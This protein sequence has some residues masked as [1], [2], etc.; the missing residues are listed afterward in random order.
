M[1]KQLEPHPDGFC[2]C[3]GARDEHIGDK[4]CIQSK[5]STAR[6]IFDLP[7]AKWAWQGDAKVVERH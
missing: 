4:P 7:L 3:G 5:P 2:F 1:A 6:S